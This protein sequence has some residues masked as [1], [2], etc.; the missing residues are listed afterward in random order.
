MNLP[1]RWL[2]LLRASL[3]TLKHHRFE[4]GVAALAVL[5]LGA[6]ALAIEYQLGALGLPSE[7]IR[8]LLQDGPPDDS[9]CAR[10]LINAWTAIINFQAGPLMGMQ[11]WIP[12]LVGLLGGVPIVAREL[13]AGTTQTAWS[14][15]GSRSRW[16]G[17][18]LIPVMVTLGAASLFMAV[19]ASE[20]EQHRID[21]GEPARL[22]SD[23]GL[24][25]I[26][27]LARTFAAFGLGLL[28]GALIGR[29]LPA[30][31]VGLAFA[32][33]VSAGVGWAGDQWLASQPA[34]PL[35]EE[36]A[37]HITQWMWLAPDGTLIDD[38]H[39]KALVPEDVAARDVGSP[40]AGHSIVWL[41]SQG[42]QLVAAGVSNEV[43]AG[44]SPYFSAAL[45]GVGATSML[46]ATVVVKRRRPT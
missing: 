12:L 33:A 35:D 37:A 23:I 24:H 11:S 43:A 2:V 21:W 28:A 27:A 29:S 41:Q 20:I 36:E 7:C 6:W 14:L 30:F 38:A 40:Q 31:V 8:N 19:M 42:F 45:A 1:P 26:P 17:A 34:A 44:W 46:L 16:L 15:Y 10:P 4:V 3:V 13:E 32:L 5:A 22:Y 18:Q 9:R 25:G 39:A